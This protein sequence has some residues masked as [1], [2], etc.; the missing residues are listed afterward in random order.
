MVIVRTK[1]I[2]LDGTHNHALLLLHV[3]DAMPSLCFMLI[4]T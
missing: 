4:G 2:Y 1:S 3:L